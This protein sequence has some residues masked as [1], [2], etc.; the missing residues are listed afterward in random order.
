MAGCPHLGLPSPVCRAS[1]LGTRPRIN[2]R[3]FA[4]RLVSAYPSH[5][6]SPASTEGFQACLPGEVTAFPGTVTPTRGPRKAQ[7]P[8]KAAHRTPPARPCSK[9]S[10]TICW[11]RPELE[12]LDVQSTQC[13]GE[14]ELLPSRD[15]YEIR[16]VG[17]KQPGLC[18]GWDSLSKEYFW[19][20]GGDRQVYHPDLP[21]C[22]WKFHKKLPHR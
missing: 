18:E 4:L 21:T 2:M 19:G 15:T 6:L 5:K 13:R 8:G 11:A 12:V 14:G 22:Q 9:H 10:E 20:S 16:H 3:Y 1:E 17:E 7:V